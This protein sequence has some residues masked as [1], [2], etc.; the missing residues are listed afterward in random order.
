[1]SKKDQDTSN[2]NG[3]TLGEISTIRDILMGGHINEFESKFNIIQER[4]SDM[5]AKLGQKIEELKS[6]ASSER[7]SLNKEMT[8]RFVKLE[9]GTDSRFTHLENETESRFAQLEQSLKDGLTDLQQMM[10]DSSLNDKEK[11]GR[12]LLEAGNSLLK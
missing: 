7:K 11:I 6:E 10:E 3:A 2:S 12:L 5:E 8:A 9:N 4:I 1:M